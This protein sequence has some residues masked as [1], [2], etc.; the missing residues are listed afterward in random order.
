[1]GGIQG[2]EG[3]ANTVLVLISVNSLTWGQ[4]LIVP[5]QQVETACTTAAGLD[6]W[7]RPFGGSND[8]FSGVTYQIPCTSDINITIHNS[9]KITVKKYQ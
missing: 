4:L 2:W 1:M 9:D 8:A 3:G 6:M 5:I 7:L